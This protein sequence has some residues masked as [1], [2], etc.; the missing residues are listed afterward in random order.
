MKREPASKVPTRVFS[1]WIGP[2]RVTDAREVNTEIVLREHKANGWEAMERDVDLRTKAVTV[3]RAK[4]FTTKEAALKVCR[5]WQRELDDAARRCEMNSACDPK[6]LLGKWPEGCGSPVTE[7]DLADA[8]RAALDELRQNWPLYADALE[9]LQEAPADKRLRTALDQ[10][11]VL[12]LAAR[13]GRV[14]QA[15][16]LR[17]LVAAD[18][19]ATEAEFFVALGAALSTWRKASASKTTN[20]KR[21]AY[22]ALNS[23]L[24]L[25][26][27]DLEYCFLTDAELASRLNKRHDL[28]GGLRQTPAGMKR[29]RQSLGLVTKR[30]PGPRPK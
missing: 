13:T 20:A 2:V 3:R 18:D 7:T 8:D 1:G 21:L 28:K 24:R 16:Q 4:K 17:A 23:D 19:P 29:R 25:N 9:A 5:R 15:D 22:E 10:A 6:R 26:W 30:K 12:D 27:L 11:F 14:I